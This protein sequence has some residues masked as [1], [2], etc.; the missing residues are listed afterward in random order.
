MIGY[1]RRLR[2]PMR[3]I[4][5]PA[6]PGTNKGAVKPAAGALNGALVQAFAQPRPVEGEFL[7]TELF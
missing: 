4:V 3:G 7:Q 1:S 5:D 6:I 2:L